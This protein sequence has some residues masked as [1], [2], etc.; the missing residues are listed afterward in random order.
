[1]TLLKGQFLRD[2]GLR[3]YKSD[4]SIL[5]S[6]FG[7][8]KDGKEYEDKEKWTK[9]WADYRNAIDGFEY[10]PKVSNQRKFQDDFTRESNFI[11]KYV[12]K[13]TY[14]K[15]ISKGHF[16]FGTIE[17]YQTTENRKIKDSEEG[18]TTL[19]IKTN[20]RELNLSVMSG[21]NYYIFCGTTNFRQDKL[22]CDRFGEY[23][24]KIN[25]NSFAKAVKKAIGAKN[26]FIENVKYSSAKFHSI[27]REVDYNE[28]QTGQISSELFDIIQNESLIP[29]IFG[30]PVYYE[31]E[32]EVRLIFEM[33]K[34]CK[35]PMRIKNLG[36]LDFIE[37]VK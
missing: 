18:C 33:S 21:F 11:Y 25:I 26:Y 3:F 22:L 20:N 10:L 24:L 29:S 5:I 12:S 6:S 8:L 28:I 7:V 15:F 34:D 17:Y 30:K 23:L 27:T 2:K 19:Y 13:E 37:I 32:N 36:L 31:D 16:Q 1:M 35:K 14:E 9:A 4:K